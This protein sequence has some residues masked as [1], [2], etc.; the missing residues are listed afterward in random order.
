MH[1]TSFKKMGAFVS[2]YI[3]GYADV[4]L[5]VLDVGASCV[6]GNKSYRALF[7]SKNW[8]YRGLDVESG[9]NV[10]VVVS[11]SY[12]WS[13]IADASIDVVVSGQVFEHIE[14]PWLTITEVARVLK[15]SGI[16]CI[17]VPSSGPEHRYP[18]DCWRIY[19]DG[20]RALARHA[21]L[22]PVEIFTEWG[23]GQWHDTF[24]VLQ[25][26]RVEKQRNSPFLGL[27]NLSVGFEHYRGALIGKPTDPSYYAHLDL[28]EMRENNY[29]AATSA[30]RHGLEQFPANTYLRLRL[31]G[32]LAHYVSAGAG[33]EHAFILISQNQVT[34]EVV[35]AIENLVRKLTV[36]EVAYFS[37]W[38]NA[39]NPSLIQLIAKIAEKNDS[40][41]LQACC[42]NS[43]SKQSPE[44]IDYRVRYALSLVGTDARVKGMQM[45]RGLV[46]EQLDRGF[47]NRTTI[48]Q[49]MINSWCAQTYL[50]IGVE[51]G[52]NFIQIRAP[53]K[54]AVDP[55]LKIPGG[56]QNSDT[57]TY[58]E[59]T[60]NEFFRSYV[61]L[62]KPKGLDIVFIDGLH[63][64]EQALLDVENALTY[65]NPGGA[66][67]IHDCLP[68]SAAEACGN[69]SEAIKHIQFN[70]SWTGDVFRTI[71]YLRA[72]RPDLSVFVVDVDHGVG[73][74]TRG[75]PESIV[76]F[77][78]GE[79]RNIT[80]EEFNTQKDH[81]LNL[82][83]VSYFK[84]WL[85]EFEV[86]SES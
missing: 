33:I 70:D 78:E 82:K 61:E 85:K 81:L 52:A 9:A 19:P 73:I 43:L 21:G 55:A 7:D 76:K 29:A 57:E 59:V 2:A 20:I 4:H 35:S 12:D 28:L 60:S 84:N 27:T 68:I 44:T 56:Y 83:T 72:I 24:A 1:V 41:Y 80:F 53:F 79:I 66:I 8:N 67:V 5:E 47:V 6:D 15:P 31:M 37:T 77:S 42:W 11:D 65:L 30:L 40:F 25:K 13:E 71:I 86:G 17:I 3:G 32:L 54:V 23:L 74:I 46:D 62:L 34:V 51:R 64:Y 48:L 50:E 26:P 49:E 18:V 45:L 63:T 39:I 14:F 38:M 22:C 69:E 10:D 58:V 16:A 36:K 75:Q